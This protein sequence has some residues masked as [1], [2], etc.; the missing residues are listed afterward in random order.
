MSNNLN[1]KLII[2]FWCI[3]FSVGFSGVISE[4]KAQTVKEDLTPPQISRIVNQIN[5]IEDLPIKK[6][7]PVNDRYAAAIVELSESAAPYLIEKLTD[8]KDSKFAYLYQY[9]IGDVARSLLEIIYDYPNCL[10]PDCQTK[11]SEKYGDYRDY[12]EFFDK[13]ENRKQLQKSWQ[14]FIKDKSV[15]S[16]E[17]KGCGV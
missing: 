7:E 16:K 2:F 9:K 6:G 15:S 17:K 8:R 14:N 4:I 1:R 13:T 12:V 10:F 5:L 3:L 11:L